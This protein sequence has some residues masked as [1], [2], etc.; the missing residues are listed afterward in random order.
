M[1]SITELAK[2]LKA[3]ENPN[4]PSI[5]TGQVI[6]PPPDVRIKLNDHIVLSAKNLV[7]AANMLSGYSRQSTF[8]AGSGTLTY[9]DHSIKSGDEVIL[10]PSTDQQTYFVLDKAVKL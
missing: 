1:D 4:M 2:M 9:M 8:G 7:F 3:R 6:S 5:T 10:M